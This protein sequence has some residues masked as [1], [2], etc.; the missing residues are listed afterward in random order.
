MGTTVILCFHIVVESSVFRPHLSRDSVHLW[1]HP[2]FWDPVDE[3][4][5]LDPLDLILVYYHCLFLII[6][7]LTFNRKIANQKLS[8]TFG[9]SQLSYKGGKSSAKK[10]FLCTLK[11]LRNW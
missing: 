6:I 11:D 2:L 4:P 5:M 10:F 3:S 1:D 9:D 7:T 8:P